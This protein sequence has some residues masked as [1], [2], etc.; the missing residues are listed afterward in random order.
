MLMSGNSCAEVYLGISPMCLGQQY[1]KNSKLHCL[2]H[3]KSY[4]QL[5]TGT[6]KQYSSQILN[7]RANLWST[8]I[9]D[10]LID[11]FA[12]EKSRKNYNF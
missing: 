5:T 12:E 9:F 3:I 1:F 8:L 11:A 10:N 2:K 4:L 7:I 6:K